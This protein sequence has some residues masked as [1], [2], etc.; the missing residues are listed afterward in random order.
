MP[1]KKKNI[2]LLTTLIVL[3][4]LIGL[5]EL[6][7]KRK[8]STVTDAARFAIADTSAIDKIKIQSESTHN[9]LSRTDS[10][11][12]V[13][14]K[15]LADPQIVQ[16]LLAVLHD[17]RIHRKVPA[18]QQPE[19]EDNLATRGFQITIM[20][21]NE[22]LETYTA[23]GNDNKTQTYF[24][25][26]EGETSYIVHLPGYNSYLAGIF[27]IPERDWRNR[28]IF[29][30]TW[31]SLQRLSMHYPQSPETGFDIVFNFNFLSMPD[32][33]M[34]DT[35][36][37]M[38][39]LDRFAYFQADQFIGPGDDDVFDSL[40]RTTPR[41]LL[42]VDE[43]GRQSYRKLA[44]FPALPGDNMVLGLLDDSTMALFDKNRLEAVLREKSY[45]SQSD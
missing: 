26:P 3:I 13:N 1:Q 11:W 7:L 22:I 2:I 29:S 43:T 4:L 17:V 16:V 8:K 25:T 27:E 41:A 35:A 18:T 9:T 6:T 12:V 15:F 23:A 40:R 36:R 31:Q 37:M 24:S 28:L 39:Y 38:D 45:F 14:N 19:V 30:I 33:A 20:A 5:A 44:I 32:V 34:L 42:E 10:G 21:E